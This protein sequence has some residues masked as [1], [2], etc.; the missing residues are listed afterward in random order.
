MENIINNS[1][2]C[3]YTQRDTNNKSKRVKYIYINTQRLYDI[4]FKNQ[5]SYVILMVIECAI[6]LVAAPNV[7]PPSTL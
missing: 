3:V 2:V 4:N 7:Q 5:Y 6:T 1:M